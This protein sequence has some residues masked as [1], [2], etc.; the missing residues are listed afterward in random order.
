[1]VRRR[2]L[3]GRVTH[4][5]YV[6]DADLPAI[7]S[8]ALALV[9]PSLYEGFGLPVLEAMACGTP[10]LTSNVSALPETAGDAALLVDPFSIPEIARA[11]RAIL[12]E[13]DLRVRLR[14]AGL[15][16]ARGFSWRRTA[17]GTLAVYRSVLDGGDS[18]NRGHG[19]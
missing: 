13:P 1:M 17:E 5:G 3:G 2:G 9:Y 18:G 19:S 16:R 10:V 14:E 11:L 4:L 12:T 8:G 15:A 6:P 7:I